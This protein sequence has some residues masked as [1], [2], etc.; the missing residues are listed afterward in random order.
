M[1][2]RLQYGIDDS[3]LPDKIKELLQE[4][5]SLSELQ[6]KKI[7][8]AKALLYSV[9]NIHAITQILEDARKSLVDID[10]SLADVHAIAKGYSDYLIGSSSPQ[11][12][13]PPTSPQTNPPQDAPSQQVTQQ[14]L[15]KAVQ[16][17]N[18]N[19]PNTED[20]ITQMGQI[21]QGQEQA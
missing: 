21:L 2:V 11:E 17:P 10:Q 12:V 3:L 4:T 8:A 5:E 7:A 16:K 1:R 9:G 19:Q 18:S 15:P 20:V 14:P 13:A 6:N